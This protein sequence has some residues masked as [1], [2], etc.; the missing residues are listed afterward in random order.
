SNYHQTTDFGDDADIDYDGIVFTMHGSAYELTTAI[1]AGDEDCIQLTGEPNLFK[2]SLGTGVTKSAVQENGITDVAIN[3]IPFENRTTGGGAF[4]DGFPL[5]VDPLVRK[6]IL[7]CLNK[8]YINEETMLGLSTPGNSVIQPGYWHLDPTPEIPFDPA[9]AKAMLL[10]SGDYAE[11]SG[12]YLECVVTDPD[13]WRSDYNGVE[14]SGIRCQAPNTDPSYLKV[15][16]AWQSWAAN[17]D[18]GLVAEVKSEGQMVSTAWYKADYDIWVWH[19]GWGPEPLSTLSCWLTETMKAGGDNCQMP[20]GPMDADGVYLDY[21]NLTLGLDLTCNYNGSIYDQVWYLA[22]KTMETEDRRQLVYLLQQWVYDSMCEYPPFYDVGLYGYTEA[23]FTNWGDWSAHN[24]QNFV[25]GLPWLWFDLEPVGA[26]QVSVG[27]EAIYEIVLGDSQTFEIEVYDNE[28]DKIWANW[29]FGD[30]SFPAVDNYTAVDTSTNPITFRQTHTYAALATG[31]EV[32]VSITDGDP[33]HTFTLTAEVNV[34]S[35]Y[36]G[37]PLISAVSSDPSSTAYA[38]EVVTWTA[39]FQDDE[40]TSLKVTWNWD[41]GTFTVN[42]LTPTTIGAAVVDEQTHVWDLADTYQ[43]VASVWDGYLDEDGTHNQ[44]T[45]ILDNVI[46]IIDNTEP[47]APTVAPI[48]TIVNVLTPC[49]AVTSDLDAD[50][51][52]VTWEWDDGTFSVTTHD[53]SAAQGEEVVSSVTHLWDTSGSYPVTVWADDG[54]ADH[55]VSTTLTAVVAA[56]GENSAP[57]SLSILASPR[58]PV[59]GITTT[60]TVSAFDANGDAIAFTVDF[61]DGSDLAFDDTSVASL[62]MQSAVFV[63]VYAVAEDVTI[64]LYAFDGTVNVSASFDRTVVEPTENSPPTLALQTS[65]TAR[66]NQTFT[67]TPIS[68]N[69]VD[70]DDVTVWYDW[71]DET[72]KTMGDPDNNYAA[73]HVYSAIG[74]FTMNASVNDGTGMA[75]HNVSNTAPVGVS[76]ANLKPKFT[77]V[78]KEPSKN[79][80]APDEMI[81]INITVR[82]PEGDAITVTVDFG[83]GSDVVSRELDAAGPNV[84]VTESFEHAYAEAGGYSITIVIEDEYDHSVMPWNTKTLEV[85]VAS[86]TNDGNIL[87]YAGVGLLLVIVIV[88]ALTLMK[89]K[90][91]GAAPDTDGMSGMEGMTPDAPSTPPPPEEPS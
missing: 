61:G 9:G 36:D 55:N 82:D 31:L 56:E 90:K 11:G 64:T 49:Q 16:E 74:T 62:E 84:N 53:T 12:D 4:G 30:G 77:T 26:P 45:G 58:P 27:L 81:Y 13:D 32:S 21:V 43:V 79:E 72:P 59:M 33:E 88:A 66:Y 41:D 57:S 19:W 29:S 24:G 47:E 91:K 52:T 69:D 78:V 50:E 65:Y 3:A 63:H 15:A 18:I 68:V 51:I 6:A 38:E 44:S 48:S 17:A 67:I 25:S 39:T 22:G 80:Y 2:T 73:T 35:T 71:G 40:A 86:A 10:A 42:D 87:L 8:T 37:N 76:E 83:D 89:R 7:M 1:N 46:E 60:L 85:D 54:V 75:G 23:S 20:M 14:L 70:G 34:V 28:G 5:L